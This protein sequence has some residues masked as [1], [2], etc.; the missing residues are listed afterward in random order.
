MTTVVT[1]HINIVLINLIN[2]LAWALVD[3]L[4]QH[5]AMLLMTAASLSPCM[6]SWYI[7]GT[8]Q[9]SVSVITHLYSLLDYVDVAIVSNISILVVPGS[10]VFSKA[11]SENLLHIYTE[12]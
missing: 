12:Q 10:Y 1:C 2:F 6:S 3:C 7:A 5:L 8:R 11:S 4:C 9:H